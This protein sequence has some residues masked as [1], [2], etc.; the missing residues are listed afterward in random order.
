MKIIINWFGIVAVL[1]LVACD[2]S[3]LGGGGDTPQ[4]ASGNTPVKYIY[5]DYLGKNCTIVARFKDLDSCENHKQLDTAL[6][7]RVS[8]PGK[9]VCNTAH[10][11]NISSAFCTLWNS[12]WYR[13]RWLLRCRLI[14]DLRRLKRLSMR[15]KKSK[16]ANIRK[17]FNYCFCYIF[18]KFWDMS[19]LVIVCGLS[20]LDCMF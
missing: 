13:Y 10:H 19:P 14:S 2:S 4:T 8:T 20:N 1:S 5:C 7:D 15:K 16:K 18:M 17:T 3:L 6:C 9:V 12:H 11:S